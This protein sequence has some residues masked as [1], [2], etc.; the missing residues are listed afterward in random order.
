M[1]AA[2]RVEVETAAVTVEEETAEEEREVAKEAVVKAAAVRAAA[3]MVVVKEV[4]KEAAAMGVVG[5]VASWSSGGVPCAL[6]PVQSD[7][8][9][10]TDAPICLWRRARGYRKAPPSELV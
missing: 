4:E 2:A 9:Y 7:H 6:A 8:H 3:V 10:G 1:V 5:K